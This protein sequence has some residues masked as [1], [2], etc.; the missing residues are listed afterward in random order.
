MPRVADARRPPGRPPIDRLTPDP[1][2]GVYVR[3]PSRDYDRFCDRARAAGVSVP[4]IVRREL[5]RVPKK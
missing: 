3:M 2:V 4:E 1:S 5:Q